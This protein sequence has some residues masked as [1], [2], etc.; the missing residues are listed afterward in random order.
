M[1]DKRES[2]AALAWLV[3]AGAEPRVK[4]QKAE[5]ALAAARTG[6]RVGLRSGCGSSSGEMV[7]SPR[8]V[9]RRAP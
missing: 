6:Q 2:L 7:L 3:E 4:L 9:T 5:E 8:P 1:S